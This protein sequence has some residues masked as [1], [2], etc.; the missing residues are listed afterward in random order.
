MSVRHNL[1]PNILATP[2]Q[3]MCGTYARCQRKLHTLSK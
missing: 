2:W 1:I 3:P